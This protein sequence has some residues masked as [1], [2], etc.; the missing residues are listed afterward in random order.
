V[1]TI[2]AVVGSEPRIERAPAQPGDVE[3]TWADLTRARAE[4]N[5]NPA[6]RL[7]D[8]VERQWAW[9]NEAR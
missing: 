6:T 5:Y 9:M 2:A 3:R 8:G 4:L 1:S 7:R